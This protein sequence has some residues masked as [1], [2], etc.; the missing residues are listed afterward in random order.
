MIRQTQSSPLHVL[1]FSA[2]DPARLP[3]VRGVTNW[4]R[5]AS[6]ISTS[7]CT[8]L[9]WPI[10]QKNRQPHTSPLKIRR[11]YGLHRPEP[12][13]STCFFPFW[14]IRPTKP[15]IMMRRK[16]PKRRRPKASGC[17]LNGQIHPLYSPW[18]VEVRSNGGKIHREWSILLSPHRECWAKCTRRPSR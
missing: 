4:R 17:L 6:S 15:F 5:L 10:Y 11:L 18:R 12:T 9:P 3:S 13:P 2:K 7:L 1:R 14:V 16:G 8:H